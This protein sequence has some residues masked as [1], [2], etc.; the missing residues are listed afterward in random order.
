MLPSVGP[1][2]SPKKTLN[3]TLL[4][5]IVNIGAVGQCEQMCL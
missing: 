4:I 3:L 1:F 5:K 2:L